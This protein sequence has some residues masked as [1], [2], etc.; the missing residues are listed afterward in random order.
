LKTGQPLSLLIAD[1]TINQQN[2]IKG[3]ITYWD[4]EKIREKTNIK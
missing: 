3:I 2:D 4:I 1:G